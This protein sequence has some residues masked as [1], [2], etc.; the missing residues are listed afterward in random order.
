MKDAECKRYVAPKCNLEKDEENLLKK[1]YAADLI[2]WNNVYD[3][4]R[5]IEND[6]YHLESTT[7]I[8]YNSRE[9]FSDGI[10]SNRVGPS[11]PS[12][13]KDYLYKEG[14]LIRYKKL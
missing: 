9:I 13:Q 10:R 4:L 3:F 14:F 1:A 7:K 11:K 6:C 5:N 2:T 8:N 12:K